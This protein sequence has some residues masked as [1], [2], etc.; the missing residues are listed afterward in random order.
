MQKLK[1]PRYTIIRPKDGEKGST[2]LYDI[3]LDGLSGQEA[4]ALIN[5]IKAMRIH[6]WWDICFPQEVK[7]WI[8]GLRPAPAPEPNGE[9]SY[10]AM[11]REEKPIYPLRNERITVKRVRNAQE[12][13]LW[14]DLTNG[15]FREGM[16]IHP[17][18]HYHLCEQENMACY[19]GYLDG[20][21][22]G[23]CCMMK[24]DDLAALYLVATAPEHRHQGV[25]TAVCTGAIDNAEREGAQLFTVC[26]WPSIKPLMRKLGYMYY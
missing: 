6:V 22:A 8:F 11:L 25:A 17:E 1:L 4:K 12:F 24:K 9:E 5:E 19:I 2:T 7:Q 18:Y 20:Q 23:V 14:A 13:A 26:A 15:F 21:A 16:L 10:M 3:N